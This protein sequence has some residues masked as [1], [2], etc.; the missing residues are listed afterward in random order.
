MYMYKYLLFCLFPLNEGISVTSSE[1]DDFK[2]NVVGIFE[3]IKLKLETSRNHY[4]YKRVIVTSIQH[5]LQEK[6]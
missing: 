4:A 3:T 6:V 2:I 1:S 5:Q